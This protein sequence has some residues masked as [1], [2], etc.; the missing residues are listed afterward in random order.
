MGEDM[1]RSAVISA[2]GTYRYLLQR[3]WANEGRAL[4]FIMLN[5]ST[6][7]AELDDPTIRRCMGFARDNGFGGIAVVN[8]FAFRS[9]SPAGLKL[10]DDPVGPENDRYLSSLFLTAREAGAPIIAA[11]GCHGTY[12]GRD[13]DVGSLARMLRTPLYTLGTTK[14]GH[15]RHPLYVS[16][17]QPFAPNRDP[18]NADA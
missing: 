14:Q 8:L 4:P 18:D 15:P 6:A 17:S 16:A 9:T 5:P 13:K 7:D 12:R 10:A 11:W 3:A 1:R 2:C